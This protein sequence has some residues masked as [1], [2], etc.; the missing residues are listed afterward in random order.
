MET[1]RLT[2]SLSE[3]GRRTLNGGTWCGD[4]TCGGC[5]QKRN[6]LGLNRNDGCSFA[7]KQHSIS[8]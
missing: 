4:V 8:L 7:L 1:Y 6:A 3:C 5:L 2:G